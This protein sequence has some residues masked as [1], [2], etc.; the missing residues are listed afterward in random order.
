MRFRMTKRSAPPPYLDT[1]PYRP[2]ERE[3]APAQASDTEQALRG[4]IALAAD[5]IISAD[6]SFRITLFNPAAE[7]IFGYSASEV[8]G[9]PLELLLPESQRD[10]HHAHLERFAASTTDA[11]AMGERGQIWGRRKWGGLFPA[12]AAVSR[13]RIGGELHLTAV[14]R[15]VSAQRRAE[16]ERETLL[17]REMQAR[18]AAESAERRMEY[19]ATASDILHSSLAVEETF[20]V[21]LQLIVP[22]LASCCII[23]VVEE[24]GLVRRAHVVHDDPSK[25]TFAERIRAYPREQAHFLTR[26]VIADGAA[27]VVPEVTDAY[28]QS[29]AE[30]ETHLE[31]LRGLGLASLI[32]V[33]L[34]A[35]GHT[36][37]GMTLARDRSAP[38]YGAADLVVAEQ[39]AQ[40]A[41][42]ALDNARLYAR[43]RQAIRVRDDVLGVV[44]HDLRNPLGVISMSATSLLG[45]GF[46]DER[47]DR[48]VLQTIRHSAHWAQRLIQDLLD[49]SA[50]EAGGLSLERRREDPVLLVMRIVMLHDAQAAERGLTLATALPDHLPALDVDADR[51]VQALGNL[52]GNAC[53]FTP[54]GGTIRI[55]AEQRGD[56]VR[57]VV[58]DTGPGIPAEHAP[59][60][61]DRFWTARRDARARGMGMGLAIVRGIAEAHG[62]RVALEHLGAGGATFVVTLPIPS[63][64]SG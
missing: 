40:R 7:R 64:A 11:R 20:V 46:A 48:E 22:E 36:L 27:E 61:F 62:G 23:D 34:R 55:G 26:R 31:L 5:A 53:K 60:I 52:V 50:I 28:L 16:V 37:G 2:I 56:T 24:S 49:V 43:A 9:Q 58:A 32:I 33:P 25:A 59:H 47:R 21:L 42:S 38:A 4:I 35:H 17:A 15:D 13:L 54:R 45:E 41:A 57:F 29:I 30:E 44:S 19:L 63:G 39:L 6:E 14:L 3:A 8:L 12:E 18:A 51:I 10:A 1:L